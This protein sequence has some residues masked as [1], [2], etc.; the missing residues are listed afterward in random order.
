MTYKNVIVLITFSL[1]CIINIK[2]LLNLNVFHVDLFELFNISL[3]INNYYI[4]NS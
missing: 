1:K 2:N 4:E 3:K